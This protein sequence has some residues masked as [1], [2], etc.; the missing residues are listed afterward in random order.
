MTIKTNVSAGLRAP[1]TY[2]EFNTSAAQRGLVPLTTRV[3][4]IGTISSAASVA[5][6]TVT[7]VFTEAEADD[8]WGTGSELALMCRWAIKACLD[9][10][11]SPEIWA[12]GI[13]D[14]AG[15]A[16]TL[17]WTVTGTAS[18]DGDLHVRLAGRDVHVAVS[19]GDANTTVAA[20]LDAAFGEY[21]TELPM[22]SGVVSNVV[23]TTA[24]C[25]GVNGND[26]EGDEVSTPAGI[27][28]AIATGAAGVGAID[29]TNT[30]ALLL[31]KDYAMVAISN[32]AAADVADF[33]THLATAWGAGQKRWRHTLM[34]ERGSLATGQALA[35]AADEYGQM[36]VS[37]EG[38]RNTC[39]ELAA[40]W[41]TIF[42]AEDDPAAS[43][44]LLDAPSL[45]PPEKADIP[46]SAEIESGIGG[47]MCVLTMN[48]S[49]TKARL[50]RAVTTQVTD[51]NSNQ[52]FTM[53]DLGISK[54]MAYTAKQV[55]AKLSGPEFVRAKKLA[56]VQRAIRSATL[57]VLYAMEK[58]ERL[59][60]IDDH[61]GE[62]QV[63]TDATVAT[64]CNVA[65]PTPVVPILNQSVAVM[66]LI[67]E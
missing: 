23:T 46:T 27:S 1:G 24:V 47:G 39:A 34:A 61:A 59:H 7:Q 29:V 20:D 67:I 30:L 45:Y 55:D 21:V 9:Y 60:N 25:T 18:A 32:H 28:L 16:A 48:E 36:V 6:G 41:A 35:T 15:T 63:E 62:L 50:V 42:A 64:R 54:T 3:C 13:A 2:F 38:F 53:L 52:M 14:P 26:I 40:Y 43:F 22:T 44:N 12:I 19:N 8:Y 33:A 58:L 17:T 10:G 49:Q 57:D 31:D 56:R 4:L 5:A 11:K 51:G 65:I 37:A 66:N